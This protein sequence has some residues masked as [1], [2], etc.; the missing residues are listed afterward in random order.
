MHAGNGPKCLT[1]AFFR[2][3]F[4]PLFHFLKTPLDGSTD[5]V[6][7]NDLIKLTYSQGIKVAIGYFS[8]FNLQSILTISRINNSSRE[9]FIL[10]HILMKNQCKNDLLYYSDDE[11]LQ[12]D[13][14]LLLRSD[15]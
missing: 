3:F 11:G 15:V 4:Q 14:T 13:G 5:P 6:E 7:M 2:Q 1:I 12:Q 8:F 9:Q 10:E